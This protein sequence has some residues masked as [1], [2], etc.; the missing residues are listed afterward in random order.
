ME[1]DGVGELPEALSIRR[2]EPC[3]TKVHT[4]GAMFKEEAEQHESDITDMY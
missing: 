3:I 1:T 2:G 4:E